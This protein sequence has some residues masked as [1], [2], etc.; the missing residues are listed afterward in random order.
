MSNPIGETGN[1]QTTTTS[2]VTTTT[3]TESTGS[4]STVSSGFS[5]ENSVSQTEGAGSENSQGG[6]SLDSPEETSAT[7]TNLLQQAFKSRLEGFRSV[8]SNFNAQFTT[9]QIDLSDTQTLLLVFRGLI[10]DIKALNNAENIDSVS[11]ERQLLQAQR[12]EISKTQ[13][14]IDKSQAVIDTKNLE[15]QGKQQTLTSK[16][17]INTEG[18]TDT[19]K[20]QLQSEIDTLQSEIAALSGEI[21]T[22]ESQNQTRRVQVAI[23]QALL[24]I[25]QS[26][27]LIAGAFAV[28]QVKSEEDEDLETGEEKLDAL[29]R[30]L[31]ELDALFSRE[32]LK[33]RL[34]KEI[35]SDFNQEVIRESDRYSESIQ[36][37]GLAAELK[38]LL[39]PQVVSN[40]FSVFSAQ[41][42][43]ALAAVSSQASP[44]EQQ[45]ADAAEGLALILLAEPSVTASEENP[46]DQ[47]YLGDSI[48]LEG[49]N[50]PQ[51]F[52][53]LLLRERMADI[54]EAQGKNSG[55]IVVD[56]VGAN[57]LAQWLEAEREVD[58]MVVETTKDRERSEAAI[59]K[60]QPV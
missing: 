27:E 45:L 20:A 28:T 29:E 39:S 10:S 58:A 2:P 51:A 41:D 53:L 48:S 34:A 3:G 11:S 8:F 16:Q 4:G 12:A 32:E 25:T 21:S 6:V 31:Q 38:A 57:Q 55:G 46:V 43:S 24:V 42:T 44:S 36:P 33:V 47:P 7:S 56:S 49:A 9:G 37:Q 15:L 50:N 54:Q 17:S 60:S 52:A 1:T 22:L 23:R 30:E 5:T 35:L 59:S 26:S 40:L 19:E 13:I 14:E 18:M